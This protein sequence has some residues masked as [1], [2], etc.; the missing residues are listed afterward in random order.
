MA[1]LWP[2]VLSKASKN[3]HGELLSPVFVFCPF[4]TLLVAS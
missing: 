4:C 2:R 3:V 1:G